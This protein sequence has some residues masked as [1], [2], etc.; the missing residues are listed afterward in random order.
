MSTVNWIV[1]SSARQLSAAERD[2]C[3]VSLDGVHRWTWSDLDRAVAD[4]AGRLAALG[5]RRGDRV[6]LLLGNSLEYVSLYF[7][8]ARLGAIAVRLNWRLTSAELA[9]VVAD[10]G[11][12]VVVFHADFAE[13]VPACRDRCEDTLFVDAQAWPASSWSAVEAASADVGTDDPVMIMYTSGT[14]GMPKGALWTHG[15]TLWC[16]A[17]QAMKF[18]FDSST[19]AMTTGPFYHAGSFETFLLPAMMRHGRAVALSSGGFTVDRLIDVIERERVTHAL[20][21]PFMLDELLHHER[22]ST[23]ALS[24]LRV[25]VSGGD[26]VLPWVVEAMN[27]RMPHVELVPTY[28]LTEGGGCCT[29]LDFADVPSRPES[30]GRPL[31]LAEI[32]IVDDGLHEVDDGAVGEIAVRSPAVSRGYW[33]N[34]EASAATFVDGWCLTGDLGVLSPDG[35]L[36]ITGRKKDM[37][38]SGGENIYPAEVEAVIQRHPHVADVA[39]VGVPDRTYVEVGCAVV[40]PV[41]G[42]V[43]VPDEL[44]RWSREHLAGYKCPK[45]YV[46]VD[47]LPRNGVGKVMKHLLRDDYRSVGDEA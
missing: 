23:D 22:T 45:Y 8:T 16:S 13:A 19:V 12:R 39:L 18:G 46:T 3:A 44:H 31:P 28:G 34:P 9:F 17:M 38:R 26:P 5:V 21:Y 36:S 10:A 2:L 29:F 1:D 11:C 40:V 35:F 41:D 4:H 24:T 32:K 47:Q 14:S 37:I 20:I 25:I 6:G 43:V 7:A 33:N 30:V 15:N 27:E 42:M